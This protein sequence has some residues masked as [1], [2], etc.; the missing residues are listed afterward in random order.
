MCTFDCFPPG[1]C[2]SARPFDCHTSISP[3]PCFHFPWC[4]SRSAHLTPLSTGVNTCVPYP[5]GW[6]SHKR[7][8]C[9][10]THMRPPLREVLRTFYTCKHI[11]PPPPCEGSRAHRHMCPFVPHP[12]TYTHAPPS[13]SEG[14]SRECLQF[15]TSTYIPFSS[16]SGSRE[17]FHVHTHTCPLPPSCGGASTDFLHHHTRAF[18]RLPHSGRHREHAHIHTHMRPFPPS[19]GQLRSLTHAHKQQE[20]FLPL[21][22]GATYAYNWYICTH[23]F[24]LPAGEATNAFYIHAHTF[25]VLPPPGGSHGR[26]STYIDTQTSPSPPSCECFH[27]DT[28]KCVVTPPR[29]GSLERF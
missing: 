22:W 12:H 16:H 14:E 3:T 17:H 27:I 1:S 24:P 6:D 11:H 10:H 29:K 19:R 21:T 15:H 2:N 18:L 23:R 9:T 13:P 28:D 25:V 4:A 26:F 5:L 20:S 8:P 7:F